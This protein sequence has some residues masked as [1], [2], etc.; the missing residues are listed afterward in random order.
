MRWS[1]LFLF[2]VG[3]YSPSY[4]KAKDRAINFCGSFENVKIISTLGSTKI[5]IT[6][7]DGKQYYGE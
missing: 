2:L 6:C 4:Q 3:C 7:M 5:D 1:I